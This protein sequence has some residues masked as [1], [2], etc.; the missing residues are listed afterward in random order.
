MAQEYQPRWGAFKEWGLKPSPKKNKNKNKKTKSWNECHCAK[1][2]VEVQ[3]RGA[4]D[5]WSG[6]DTDIHPLITVINSKV[7]VRVENVLASVL[8]GR[9][10][11]GAQHR[12]QPSLPLTMFSI[13]SCF[14]SVGVQRCTPSFLRPP[15]PRWTPSRESSTQI[16]GKLERLYLLSLLVTRQLEKRACNYAVNSFVCI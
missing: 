6:G 14:Y 3:Q 9:S 13:S 11:L 1:E 5:Q 12:V 7:S 15:K 10:Y 4:A 8:H 16:I 2:G